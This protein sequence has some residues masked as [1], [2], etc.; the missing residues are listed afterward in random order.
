MKYVPLAGRI[1]FSLIFI[2]ASFNHFTK[3]AA[4]YAASNGTPLA[5]ILVPI[6]GV[7][8][9]VG[10][11]SIVIGYRAKWGALL[12]VAFL[13][14]VT[15]FMHAFW[16]I[17]DPMQ[18]AIQTAMFMKNLSMMGGALLIFYFG[19]GPVALDKG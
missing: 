9:L 3:E 10:G 12:I 5:T 13:V 6:S 11:L 14:P 2:V 17:D 4:Q 8:S 1:L 7:M 15:Y 18:K 16:N 19:A